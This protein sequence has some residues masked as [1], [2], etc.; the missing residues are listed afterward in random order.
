M[1]LTTY[2][3]KHFDYNNISPDSID[4]KDITHALPRINRF[5]GHSSRAYSVAEHT[6]CCLDIAK[7]KGFST[8]LQLLTLIHD[9]PEAYTGDC[10][11]PLKV[12]LPEFKVIEGKVE[13]ALYQHLGIEPPT[14]DEHAWVKCVDITMLAIEM[15]DLTLHNH[16]EYVGDYTFKDILETPSFKIKRGNKPTEYFLQYLLHKSFTELMKSY[17]EEMESNE[18]V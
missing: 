3:G 4:I 12:L 9:F 10:P 14:E 8:R 5:I 1:K 18:E 17:R 16:E 6:L 2:T 7:T 15:R 11:T 13:H